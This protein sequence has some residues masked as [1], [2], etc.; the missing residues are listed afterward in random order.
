MP[1]SIGLLLLSGC[2]SGTEPAMPSELPLVVEGWIEDGRRPVVIVTR[3]ADLTDDID[4][5]D[6]YVEKWC[7]VTVDDGSTKEVL[8]GR[9]NHDY[10][11]SFVFTSS[12][13]K[14]SA[15]RTYALTVET[16]T[17]TAR[18][19]ATMPESP[20]IDSLRITPCS[21]SD[22]LYQIHAFANIDRST[23]C[24]YKFFARVHNEESRFYS[25]FLG[26]L[27]GAAYDP[28]EGF[29]VSR[30][31]HNTYSGSEKFTPYYAAG[32]TVS[33]KLCTL[34]KDVFDFWNAYENLVSLGGN[35]FFR[36]SQSCPSN[37]DGARGYWAAYGVS[38]AFAI[39][40]PRREGH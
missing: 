30:G 7:R 3:A 1:L 12:K 26:T 28:A 39:V 17:T 31:I 2:E 32:D 35:V 29:G 14:G 11:P 36:V 24:Y 19:V 5:F 10:V 13:M 38:E 34:E 25:S 20:H 40:R 33:V 8:T 22:T 37:I 21:Q 6:R 18:A 16:E 9:V 23:G 4:S 15:G 27:E